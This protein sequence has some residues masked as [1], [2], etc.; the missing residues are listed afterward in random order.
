VKTSLITKLE[1]L[2]DIRRAEGTRHELVTII[3]ITIMAF[4]SQI[5]SL[6]GIESFIKRHK[7]DLIKSLNIKKERVPSYSTLR[8]VLSA[9]DFNELAAIFR[10]W[11][12]ENDLLASDSWIS[13]DGKSIKSTCTEYC[14]NNQNFVSIVSAFAHDK[15]IVVM[16]Q[17]FQNKK[18]SE[19]PVVDSLIQALGLQD[20]TFTLD[21]LHSKKNS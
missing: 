14:S 21:A 10:Q 16:S 4:M 3:L 9:L 12:M 19:I 7:M 11:I 18:S 8:R 13:I 5:Y 20:M 6:R 2:N 15:G 17:S 1:S